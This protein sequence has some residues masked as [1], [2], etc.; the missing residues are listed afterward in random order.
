MFDGTHWFWISGSENPNQKGSYAAKGVASPDNFPGGRF[1]SI[2]W[3]D[4]S[5]NLYLYGGNGLMTGGYG[6]I[7]T[8][9]NSSN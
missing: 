6:L 1:I 3:F 8:V 4:S 9:N 5:N 7:M 2:S